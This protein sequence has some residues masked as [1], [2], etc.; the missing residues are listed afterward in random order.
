M[1]NL[2]DNKYANLPMSERENPIVLKFLK[3]FPSRVRYRGK[4]IPGI[5]N[6][7]A[8]HCIREFATTFT[9]YPR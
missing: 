3:K 1:I 9:I 7:P 2:Y 4:S 5:Y 8:S 6:R